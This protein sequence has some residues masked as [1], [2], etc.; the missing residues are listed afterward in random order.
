MWDIKE[1]SNLKINLYKNEGELQ[2]CKLFLKIAF[3]NRT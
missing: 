1:I 3:F 2:K